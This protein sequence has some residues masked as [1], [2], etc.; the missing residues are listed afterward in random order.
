MGIKVIDAFQVPGTKIVLKEGAYIMV[1]K[2]YRVIGR[3]V[4]IEEKDRY[5]KVEEIEFGQVVMKERGAPAALSRHTMSVM[6]PAPLRCD[7]RRVMYKALMESLESDR[8]KCE[9]VLEEEEKPEDKDGSAGQPPSADAA[10][11]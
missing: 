10:G 7:P 2:D 3:M 8:H 11:V 4:Y 5:E 9:A 1:S 6:V